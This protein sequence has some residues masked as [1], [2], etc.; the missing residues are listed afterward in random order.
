MGG[1]DEVFV[2]EESTRLPLYGLGD[3]AE[4]GTIVDTTG[5]NLQ[6]DEIK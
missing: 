2:F 5:P 4:S 6:F 1:H 3:A